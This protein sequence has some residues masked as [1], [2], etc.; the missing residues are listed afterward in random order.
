ME[1][2]KDK[3]ATTSGT[4]NTPAN[5][6]N[7]ATTSRTLSTAANNDNTATTS[8]TASTPANN[9]NTATT[10]RTPSTPA[11]N[12]NTATTSRTPSTAANND[13]TT[14]TSRTATNAR[15]CAACTHRRRKCSADCILAPYFPQD[16]RQQFANAHRLFGVATIIKI[17]QDLDPITRDDAMTAILY[18]SDARARDPVGGCSRLIMI[19]LSKIAQHQQE[20]NVIRQQLALRQMMMPQPQQNHPGFQE[21]GNGDDERNIPDL[22]KEDENDDDDD[23]DDDD[24]GEKHLPDLNEKDE[25][26]DDHDEKHLPDLNKEPK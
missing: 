19:L 20:L 3:T 24:D 4:V 16:R 9:D 6:D 11:N 2:D 23:D 15:S 14:T 13:N 12:D 22:N 17:I 10:S 26:D 21:E 8:R 1:N 25:N 7:T 18:E 5:N